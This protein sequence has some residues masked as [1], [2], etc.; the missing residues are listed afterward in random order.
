M[1]LTQ[2]I[3]ALLVAMSIV[4]TCVSAQDA[5]PAAK[6]IGSAESGSLIKS[7]ELGKD[8]VMMLKLLDAF[9][10]GTIDTPDYGVV[11]KFKSSSDTKAFTLKV[12]AIFAYSGWMAK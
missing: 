8:N 5:A 9:L 12:M 3:L 4:V 6:L 2:K 10:G 11:V 1:T 7:T